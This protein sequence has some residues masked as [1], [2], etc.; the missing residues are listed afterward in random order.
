MYTAKQEAEKKI[1]KNEVKSNFKTLTKT[2]NI[3][4]L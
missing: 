2:H 3:L 1:D 4:V